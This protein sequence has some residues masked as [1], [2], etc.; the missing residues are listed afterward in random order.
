MPGSRRGRRRSPTAA[1]TPIFVSVEGSR[2]MREL[3]TRLK[4]FKRED[5]R[6]KLRSRLKDAGDPT[7]KAIQAAAMRVRVTPEP[8]VEWSSTEQRMVPKK[9][10]RKPDKRRR[11]TNLRMRVARA[12]RVSVTARGIRIAVSAKRVGPYGVTLPRYLDASISNRWWRWRHPVFFP[13]SIS[14][15]PPSRVV[16]QRGQPYFFGPITSR[17]AAFRKAAFRAISEVGDELQR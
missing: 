6:K 16:Q 12:T 1:P 4:R 7:V 2:E 10:T 13:G 3:A 9:P 11:S 17:R 5:L 15:A 14:D 8:T